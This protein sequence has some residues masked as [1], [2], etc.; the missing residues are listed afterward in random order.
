LAYKPF[1]LVV[2]D[3]NEGQKNLKKKKMRCLNIASCKEINLVHHC[4]NLCAK[5]DLHRK[6]EMGWM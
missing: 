3:A 2:K 4:I 6:Y 1:A 5:K